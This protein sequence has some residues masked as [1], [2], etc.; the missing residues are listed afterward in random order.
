MFGHYTS[1]LLTM[2]GVLAWSLLAIPAC[3]QEKTVPENV[4]AAVNGSFV[5]QAEFDRE[6]NRLKTSMA[7]TGQPADESQTAEIKTKALDNL[8]YGEL[9]YQESQKQG[10]EVTDADL[11]AKWSSL[12]ERFGTEENFAQAL[13][14]MSLTEEE[15]KI[16]VRR[17]MAIERLIDREVVQK[18]TVADQEVKTFYDEH[19]DLF[20]QPAQVQA[21]HIL[22]TVKDPADQAQKDKARQKIEGIQHRLK[23]GEDFAA[24]A[25]E[26]SDCPSKEKGGELG[27]ITR[28]QTVKPFED[29]AFAL[30]PG[31]MSEIVETDFGYHIIKVTDKKAESILPY[32]EVQD[33]LQEYLKQN[34]VKDNVTQYMAA[35]KEKAE[36]KIYLK[37]AQPQE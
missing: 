11:E 7:Q 3:S 34:K 19:P 6:F 31:R 18:T 2:V 33:K 17:G 22:V 24:L 10:L 36:I 23:N 26:A 35:L 20:K 28:G 9:L 32:E 8:I 1:R 30:E 37:E 5:S 12:K 14:Q 25:R 27:Y 16:Q 13:A 29:A 21:S 4:V 15:V